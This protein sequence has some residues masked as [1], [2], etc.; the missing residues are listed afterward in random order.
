MIDLFDEY[1]DS[2]FVSYA[3]ETKL[4]PCPTDTSSVALKLQASTF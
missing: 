1:E 4:S 2:N 3:D